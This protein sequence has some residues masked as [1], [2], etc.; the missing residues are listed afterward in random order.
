MQS[1]ASQSFYLSEIPK[2]NL[3]VAV[4]SVEVFFSCFHSKLDFVPHFKDL[5][6]S[7][8]VGDIDLWDSGSILPTV[9]VLP[10]SDGDVV[11]H[12]APLLR[13]IRPPVRPV[14]VKL[15]ALPHHCPSHFYPHVQRLHLRT[16]GA[17]VWK[18]GLIVVLWGRY[19]RSSEHRPEIFKLLSF[20]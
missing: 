6:P 13:T 18:Q 2:I 14:V 4:K 11:V 17:R 15:P 8:R 1:L 19:W 7:R 3:Q 12:R 9:I 20:L 10:I 5:C 16:A